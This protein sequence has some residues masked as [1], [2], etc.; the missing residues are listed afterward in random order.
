[1]LFLIQAQQ[2]PAPRHFLAQVKGTLHLPGYA[3]L[4]LC[5][6]FPCWDLSQIDQLDG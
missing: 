5:F 3:T 1:M 2:E 4:H 6:P